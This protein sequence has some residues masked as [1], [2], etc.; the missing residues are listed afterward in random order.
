MLDAEPQTL[1]NKFM[2]TIKPSFA[3]VLTT[4]TQLAWSQTYSAGNLAGLI[5]LSF[6][7][8]SSD[9]QNQTALSEIGRNIMSNIETEYISHE[10]NNY[11][12]YNGKGNIDINQNEKIVILLQKTEDTIEYAQM[13]TITASGQIKD[14]DMI[15]LT[16]NE[17]V[18]TIPNIPDYLTS[19]SIGEIA[20]Q[21]TI[22]VENKKQP[23]ATA[24]ILL[25]NEEENPP[26]LVET[27]TEDEIKDENEEK[28][29][30][31]PE[32]PVVSL[33]QLPA[34]KT[35]SPKSFTAHIRLQKV[36]KIPVA[37]SIC[38]II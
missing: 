21:L 7:K 25:Y 31:I 26:Q 11:V 6:N 29:D 24:L 27:E 9:K 32:E 30:E 19:E 16:S 38:T 37:L 15:I 8:K 20:D 3:K 10:N 17:L 35:L 33:D 14:N 34:A 2:H 1:Y 18:T 12:G 28:N 5:T 36:K 23:N 4:S 13:Q 22:Q